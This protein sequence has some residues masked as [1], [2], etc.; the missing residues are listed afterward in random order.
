MLMRLRRRTKATETEHDNSD[1]ICKMAIDPRRRLF[2]A[3]R[4]TLSIGTKFCDEAERVNQVV[5][6][7]RL[8]VGRARYPVLCCGN[9]R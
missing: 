5:G 1:L 4:H 7:D 8:G 2:L 6:E 9:K 3:S